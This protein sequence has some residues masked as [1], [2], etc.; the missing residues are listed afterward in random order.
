MAIPIEN[1]YYLLCYAWNK[2]DEKERVSVSVDDRSD[3]LD[4]LAKVL[5]NGTKILLKRGIDKSYVTNMI[6]LAGVKGKL[7]L[8]ETVKQGIHLKQ[9]T[10]CTVDDFSANIL[11][12]QILLSCLYR[13]MKTMALDAS[14]KG[15][16]KHLI[17]MFSGIQPIE[18]NERIFRKVRLHRNNRFYG[19]ILNV[20]QL[21]YENSLPTEKPGEYLFMDFTRDEVKMGKLFES[22]IRNFYVRHLPDCDVGRTII[23][24]KFNTVNDGGMRFL[25]QMQTDITIEN[26]QEK[27]IIDA[28]YYRETMTINYDRQKIHSNNLYQLFSYLINQRSP[29]EKTINAKGILLYP[30]IE[31]EYDL[32]YKFDNHSIQIKT[33]NLNQH[34]KAIEARLMSLVFS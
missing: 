12:N 18:V 29:I 25:P 19:F 13:L 33:L 3:L 24:W 28:K 23:D 8:S 14:L 27:I 5:I 26:D 10:W 11:S 2:L 4:L 34:W 32:S 15:E 6:E 30:T 21:I 16:I 17:W 1:I 20:C 31:D 9:R 7:E 22:F